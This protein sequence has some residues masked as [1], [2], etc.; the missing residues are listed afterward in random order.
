MPIDMVLKMPQLAAVVMK[1]LSVHCPYMIVIVTPI[2]EG[3]IVV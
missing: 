3:C 2:A 1:M